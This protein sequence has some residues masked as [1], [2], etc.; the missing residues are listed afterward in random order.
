VKDH[1]KILGVAAT[2]T[3]A[4]IKKAY[5]RLALQYH[6]DKNFGN[7]LY[8]AKFKEIKEAYE[9]LT[10]AKQREEYNYSRKYQ[11]P[12]KHKKAKTVTAQTILS[13]AVAL[14]KKTT[15]VDPD[16]MNKEALFQL[17]QMLLSQQ[18]IVILQQHKD[19]N[20]NKR[21][22]EDVLFC[23]RVLPF[24]QV[25][26][27]CFQLTAVAGTDNVL[28]RTIYNFSKEAR[29]SSYWNR[30]KIYLALAIALILCF[31]IYILGSN[32]NN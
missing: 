18:N 21:V 12:E 32:N 26:K 10:D 27:I 2:A 31:A 7:Q 8:D 29:I 19:G 17:I 14:R 16:R 13:E 4:E 5:R 15:A 3:V 22:I 25:E 28:Y 1:Y 6:P 9:V 24:Q 11:Q 30:Y 20:V 23:C